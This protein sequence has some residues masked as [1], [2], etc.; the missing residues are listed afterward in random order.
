MRAVGVGSARGVDEGS[1]IVGLAV[2][3]L[4]YYS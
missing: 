1:A 4:E 3:K 2:V